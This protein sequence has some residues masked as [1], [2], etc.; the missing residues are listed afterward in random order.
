[1]N[2]EIVQLALQNLNASPLETPMSE[3]TSTDPHLSCNVLALALSHLFNTP[4]SALGALYAASG[5][6]VAL[7]QRQDGFLMD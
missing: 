1:M 3:K 6:F 2:I 7:L 4:T 5:G